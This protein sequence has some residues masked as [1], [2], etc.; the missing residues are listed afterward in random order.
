MTFQRLCG[1][2]HSQLPAQFGDARTHLIALVGAKES[3]KSVYMTVL[4]HELHHRSA[5]SSAS[6]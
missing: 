3:G 5:N 2:C 6:R 1:S 4:L